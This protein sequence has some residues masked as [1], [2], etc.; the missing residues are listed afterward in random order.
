M[1]SAVNRRP[2]AT[3]QTCR[4]A[5]ARRWDR[6]HP[7]S[8][9]RTRRSGGKRRRD[10][11]SSKA[12]VPNTKL[13]RRGHAARR[14][15]DARGWPRSAAAIGSAGRRFIIG[16]SAAYATPTD[17]ARGTSA[18]TES[19]SQSSHERGNH[20][21][22]TNQYRHNPAPRLAVSVQSHR[23][24]GG[25]VRWRMTAT[26]PMTA[27]QPTM[28]A[29]CKRNASIMSAVLVP[30]RTIRTATHTAPPSMPAAARNSRPINRRLIN[31]PPGPNNSFS[32]AA[33]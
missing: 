28:T 15:H 26:T 25:R 6:P 21:R 24:A 7:S 32:C 13:S 3:N 2:P 11:H 20:G 19:G 1:S 8:A 18:A 12:G 33:R 17:R 22:T 5:H 30:P 27:P 16:R 23:S 14:L 31:A 9:G 10:R 4:M 29:H